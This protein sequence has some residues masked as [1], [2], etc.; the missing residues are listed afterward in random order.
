MGA[1]W[2]D[3]YPISIF[4]VGGASVRALSLR[5]GPNSFQVCLLA[6]LPPRWVHL[7]FR[8]LAR[9]LLGESAPGAA[10]L[11]TG[12]QPIPGK[13]GFLRILLHEVVS[14]L[15]DIP[16]LLVKGIPCGS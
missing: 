5:A 10:R 6:R 2:G 11:C 4:Y 9:S 15:N 16:S 1:D 12:S 3:V 13:R 8:R 7:L 14:C